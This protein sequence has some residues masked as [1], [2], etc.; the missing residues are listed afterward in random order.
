MNDEGTSWVHMLATPITL[1]ARACLPCD[2]AHV[3]A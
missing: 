3:L 1:Q 2:D